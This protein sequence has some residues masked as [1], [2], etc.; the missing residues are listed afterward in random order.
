[1]NYCNCPNCRTDNCPNA[2]YPPQ[3][4][5]ADHLAAPEM[6]YYN[7]VTKCLA[8]SSSD[9]SCL[10]WHD[11]GTDLY[12]RARHNDVETRLIWRIKP[13]APDS[14]LREQIADAQARQAKGEG[15]PGDADLSHYYLVGDI[16]CL[17]KN[18]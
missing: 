15:I 11:E 14:H 1:M 7:R 18:A 10:C 17:P 3:P 5:P 16:K 12:Y 8:D 4:E 13:S 6:Q 2:I 9:E